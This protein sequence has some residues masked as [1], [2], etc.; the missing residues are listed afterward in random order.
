MAIVPVILC[1]GAGTRLWPVS[2]EAM[3][4]PFMRVGAKS[5][6][7]RTW[8]RA[9]A[10]PGVTEAAVVTNV[11]YSYKAAE[12]L[13]DERDSRAINLL[14]EPFGRNT[15]PAIALAA[16][17]AEHRFGRDAVMLVLPADHL[18]EPEGEFAVAVQDAASIAARTGSL[19]L[20]GVTP[21]APETGFG[22][23]EWGS[24][25]GELRAH[26]VL[27]FIE[28]PTA[29]RAAQLLQ[30]GNVVWNSGMFCFTVGAILDALAKY[31]PDVLSAARGVAA[32]S[33]FDG[34]QISF[35]ADS[36]ATLP[37]IS[38]D[39]AVME[40]AENVLVVPCGFGWSDIGNW[41]AVSDANPSDEA[42]NVNEGNGLFIKSRSTYIRSDNNRLVAAVGV[43]DL[44][45]VDTAD[46]VLVAHKSASQ[47]VKEVVRQLR[48][49]GNEAYKLHTTV[50]RPWGTYTTLMEA[51]GFKI[52]RI[53]VK[54]GQALSLQFHHKRA[55]HWVVVRGEA[56]VQVG[57][58]EFVTKPGQS[59]YIPRGERHRLSNRTREEVEII[60]VQCGEYLGEDDIVRLVDNYG[61]VA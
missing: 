59:R 1:G 6:L 60:E 35:A 48:E 55:E 15:A 49:I 26:K 51:E 34:S 43:T 45:V 12:E 53:V 56:L 27:R 29:E 18:V 32:A 19:V 14:L 21:T 46:A 4:K 38:I 44:V 39:Y 8:E 36:F 28:K 20:F 7:Q 50:H 54:P 58:E 61:R 25:V 57:D 33:S 47:E 10:V 17:W 2:R 9:A 37:D 13:M 41:K 40:R 3:P 24:A 42:G 5:L 31:A 16:L 52:K 30:A 23:I 22:Y 11:A